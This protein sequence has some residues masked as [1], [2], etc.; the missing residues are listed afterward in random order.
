MGIVGAICGWIGARFNLADGKTVTRI[1]VTV[2]TMKLLIF[3][4]EGAVAPS[5]VSWLR[6]LVGIGILHILFARA[7]I[8]SKQFAQ[9]RERGG[10]GA[11]PPETRWYPNLM[12]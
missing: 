4:F 5:Y 7:T 2:V 11:A 8:V 6:S 3:G 9:I 12:T 1:L 10:P